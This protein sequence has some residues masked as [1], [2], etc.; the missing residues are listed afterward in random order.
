[1]AEGITKDTVRAFREGDHAAFDALFLGYFDKIRYFIRGIVRSD[2]DAEEIAQDIF[3]KLWHDRER[4][5]PER[6]VNSLM[7][8]LA[9]NAALNFIKHRYVEH[10]YL[11]SLP[12]EPVE[13]GAEAHIYAAEIELIIKMTVAGMPDQRRTIYE[14]SREKGVSN[15]EIA[16][17]LGVAKKTVEN[18]LSLA[19]KEIRKVISAM[20][21]FFY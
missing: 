14:M 12:P 3:M 11:G 4:I 9:R 19:L 6:S 17:K 18:Q 21:I 10:S 20:L 2:H 15:D 8:T 16:G 7:Y 5:D 13:D 1:M